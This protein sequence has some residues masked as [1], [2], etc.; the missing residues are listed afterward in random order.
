M[1]GISLF[2]IQDDGS[3]HRKLWSSWKLHHRLNGHYEKWIS[4]LKL[5]ILENNF[6]GDIPTFKGSLFW[7]LER[8]L[9]QDDQAR[10]QVNFLSRILILNGQYLRFM[11]YFN[12]SETAGICKVYKYCKELFFTPLLTNIQISVKPTIFMLYQEMDLSGLPR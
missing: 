6:S 5:P 1:N 4:S 10:K 7:V 3:L 11:Y 12:K 9:M 2:D 8:F